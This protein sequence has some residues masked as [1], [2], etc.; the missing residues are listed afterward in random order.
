MNWVDFSLKFQF[1]MSFFGLSNLKELSASNQL[2]MCSESA[3]QF[4]FCSET[5][6]VSFGLN[7]IQIELEVKKNNSNVTLVS[8]RLM[9]FVSFSCS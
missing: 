4:E 6:Q 7:E 3:T 1:K 5:K 8:L 9:I 2:F